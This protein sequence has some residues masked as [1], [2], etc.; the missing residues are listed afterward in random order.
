MLLHL[1]LS[2]L[3]TFAIF[4]YY[5]T[6]QVMHLQRVRLASHSRKALT[7]KTKGRLKKLIYLLNTILK[8]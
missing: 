4:D 1:S 6:H 3:I 7:I 2:L 8:I 5:Q